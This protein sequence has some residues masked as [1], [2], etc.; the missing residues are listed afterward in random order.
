MALRM[1]KMRRTERLSIFFD[2]RSESKANARAKLLYDQLKLSQA[3]V[4]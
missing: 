3:H 4:C 1:A 2:Q